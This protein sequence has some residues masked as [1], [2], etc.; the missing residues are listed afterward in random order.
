MLRF[1]AYLKMT[2]KEKKKKE[3]IGTNYIYVLE[4]HA[5]QATKFLLYFI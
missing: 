4:Y 5:M 2:A 1:Y 3:R